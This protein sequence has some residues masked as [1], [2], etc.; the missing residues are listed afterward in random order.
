MLIKDVCIVHLFSVQGSEKQQ[1][2][3][4]VSFTC[5]VSLNLKRSEKQTKIQFQIHLNVKFIWPTTQKSKFNNIILYFSPFSFH[6]DKN[7]LRKTLP[8][9][10][11]QKPWQPT[12]L[13]QAD[14]QKNV[15]II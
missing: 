13:T 3:L 6:R 11:C 14:H 2:R 1:I 12:I 5:A 4:K 15:E 9:Q 10:S 7:I 8:K